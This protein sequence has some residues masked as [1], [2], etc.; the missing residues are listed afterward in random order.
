VEISNRLAASS[1]AEMR[2]VLR[3]PSQHALPPPDLSIWC[4]W[5]KP[6]RVC[7]SASTKKGRRY[8]PAHATAARRELGLGDTLGQVRYEP[9]GF[10]DALRFPAILDEIQNAPELLPCFRR[11]VRG[12]SFT[13]RRICVVS[14]APA[15]VSTP[16]RPIPSQPRS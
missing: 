11:S 9:R 10:L 3:W 7:L 2:S 8:E 6:C 15:R 14:T 12:G 13:S 16:A 5:K 4:A 1:R